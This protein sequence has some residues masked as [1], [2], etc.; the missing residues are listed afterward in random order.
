[1]LELYHFYGATCGLKARL[2]V[3]EKGLD[4]NDRAVERSYLKTREYLALNP[5]GLVPTLV[6]DGHVL[7]ESTI[8][9]NYL[10]DLSR[11][12]PLKPAGALG[13]A[14]ALW[15]MK[16]ADE[17]LPMI[18]ILTYTVSMRPGLRQLDAAGLRLYLD[19]IASV[20]LRT[21]RA[22]IIE[23][24]YA[25]EEFHAALVGLRSM[26]TNMEESLSRNAWL[27]GSDYSLADTAMTPL[28]QRLG[29]LDVADLFCA[30]RPRLNDWWDRIR[31]RPSYTMCVEDKPNPDAAQH[32][33]YGTEARKEISRALTD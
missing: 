21:R 9:I 16:R 30:E 4:V 29:E 18:G 23:L 12:R 10:D 33:R 1:M 2:A 28:V 14:R 31:T 20:A 22:R 27:A 6:H 7:T 32:R 8:I 26:L 13:V 3:N 24:G 19:S 15:W 17:C 25:N 11:E 5:N